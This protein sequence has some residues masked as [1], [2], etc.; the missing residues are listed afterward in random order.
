LLGLLQRDIRFMQVGRIELRGDS[1]LSRHEVVPRVDERFRRDTL[2]ATRDE[3]KGAKR[4]GT[5]GAA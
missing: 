4:K 2:T 3:A 1:A 5:C